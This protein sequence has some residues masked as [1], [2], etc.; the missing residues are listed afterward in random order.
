MNA[1]NDSHVSRGSGALQYVDEIIFGRE[2]I[3]RLPELIP[4]WRSRLASRA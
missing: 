1:I 4:V 3:E 2:L